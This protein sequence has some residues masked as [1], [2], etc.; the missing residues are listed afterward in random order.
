MQLARRVDACGGRAVKLVAGGAAPFEPG[1]DRAAP[2]PTWP[3]NYTAPAI[4]AGRLDRLCAPSFNPQRSGAPV[5][6]TGQKGIRCDSRLGSSPE[7]PPQLSAA[8]RFPNVPLGFAEQSLGRRT[9]VRTREPG[10]LPEQGHP[11]AARGARVGRAS[12][13]VTERIVTRWAAVMG[14]LLQK[15]EKRPGR[16]PVVSAFALA[17]GAC[18]A[19]LY[20]FGGGA[21]A[22]DL[23]RVLPTKVP[24]P[25]IS[26][27]DDW[28]GFY[29][30]GHFDYAAG[31]SN[32]TATQAGA[33]T[34][35]LS[36]ALDLVQGYDFSTGRGS[37]LLGFQAGYN[38]MLP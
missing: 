15:L 27:A 25:A 9:T 6:L 26:A 38:Y 4:N 29:A 20:W 14:S 34:P 36:G 28:T 22:A 12:A 31:F 10:D 23:S 11:S 19:F 21:D 5:G 18:A 35:S 8:S 3:E 33:A 17:C 30:G 7:L 16:S 32:W 2:Q 24:P 1:G 13:V 37:Y